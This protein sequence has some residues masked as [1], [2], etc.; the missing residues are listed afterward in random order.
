MYWALPRR[1]R[2]TGL[3]VISVAT[4]AWFSLPS[5][6]ALLAVTALTFAVHVRRVP[7]TWPTLA[8][9]VS[10]VLVF[11]AYKSLALFEWQASP[12]LLIG[13]A[14]YLLKALRVLLDRY[15]SPTESPVPP[16]VFCAY[17]LFLPTLLI[18]PI[19]G[20][21][22]FHADWRQQAYSTGRTSLALERL[23]WGYA[24]IVLLGSW[25][26]NLKFAFAIAGLAGEWPRLYEYLADLRYGLHL[27]FTFAGASDV[28]IAFAALLGFRI[29]ENFNHPFASSSIAE[30]WR[31]WHMSL[32]GWAR[33]YVYAPLAAVTRHHTA[34]LILTMGLIGLWHE[35]S[36]RYLIWGAYHGAGLVV[37]H[38]WVAWTDRSAAWQAV[39]QQAWYQV[40]AIC[41][42]F[43]FVMLGFGI[44]RANS[45]ADLLRHFHRLV[46]GAS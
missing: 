15:R 30:F 37:H 44:A 10:L 13:M 1:W 38:R 40:M 12:L 20:L 39:R 42:T 33:H 32:S 17:M 7:G 3:S 43:Q 34:T 8:A 27:Y 24:K 25:L 21:R 35:F 23:L 29:D 4:L 18:G 6:L 9:I 11:L 31:R 45:S 36:A 41:V 5:A 19:H 22:Q 16:D 2:L 28:A 46:F 14:F 26:I